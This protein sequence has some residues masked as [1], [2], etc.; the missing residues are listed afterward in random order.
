MFVCQKGLFFLIDL[1]QDVLDTVCVDVSVCRHVSVYHT[2]P[3]WLSLTN[4]WKFDD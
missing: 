4:E 3:A 1:N 2:D